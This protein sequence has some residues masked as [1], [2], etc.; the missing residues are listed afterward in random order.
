[1]AADR[2]NISVPSLSK[3][4]T[5]LEQN[6]GGELFNRDGRSASLSPLGENLLEEAADLLRR[7]DE[8]VSM[9]AQRRGDDRRPMLLNMRAAAEHCINF[10]A[11]SELS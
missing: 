4:I 9:A 2:L 1:M 11:P 10:G 5:E 7:A 8:F 6:I 3:R